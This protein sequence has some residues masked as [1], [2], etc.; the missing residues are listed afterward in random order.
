M[1]GMRKSSNWITGI[2]SEVS[3]TVVCIL[4]GLLLSYVAYI[5]SR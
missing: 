2:L 5:V 4:I 3:Y 1:Y